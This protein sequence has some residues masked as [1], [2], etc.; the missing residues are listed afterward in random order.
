MLEVWIYAILS[1][2]IVSL[3]SLVGIISIP[4]KLT[5][6]KTFILFLVSF[7]AGA[8]LGDAFIHLLPETFETYGFSLQISL[9][10]L[11]GIVL[12]FLIE[13]I[14]HWKHSHIHGIYKESSGK[15]KLAIINLIGDSVHNFID[16]I[17]IGVS[18]L[19][20]IPL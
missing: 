18:Y 20:S 4:F 8:L 15:R 2:I 16:G 12:F 9:F 3:I 17:V 13:K 1:V 5:K 6:N 19:I 10:V 7:S 11:G 14:V